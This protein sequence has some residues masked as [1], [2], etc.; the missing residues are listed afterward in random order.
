MP[1]ARKHRPESGAGRTLRAIAAAS[2]DDPDAIIRPREVIELFYAP[3]GRPS[4]ACR[5]L[6]LLLLA[7]AGVAAA[8]DVTHR[9]ERRRLPAG[10][11]NFDDFQKLVLEI[12]A[13]SLVQTCSSGR[14]HRAVLTVGVFHWIR[15]E[16]DPIGTAWI[17]WR[18]TPEARHWI[19][20]SSVYARLSRTVLLGLRSAYTLE[21]YQWAALLAGRDHPRWSGSV[22]DLRALLGAGQLC[23]RD[24]RRE[25]LEVAARELRPVG[26]N[27]EF[28]ISRRRGR[29]VQAVCLIFQA[30]A[31]WPRRKAKSRQIP[32]GQSL[33]QRAITTLQR[34]DHYPRDA[35]R[36]KAIERGAP[37]ESMAA[38]TVSALSK[39]A[40]WIARDLCAQLPTTAEK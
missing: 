28:Q 22:D 33:V 4:L 14:G 8:D 40:E 31:A 3:G 7:E 10:H 5:R 15:Q 6:M 9:I 24:L 2:I 1:D 13:V 37:A 20:E 18:F 32:S 23:W 11:R 35:W 25:A 26:I 34:M 21:L 17:E 29:E 19:K 12:Q 16:I 27:L 39:W 36:L 38:P 30:A